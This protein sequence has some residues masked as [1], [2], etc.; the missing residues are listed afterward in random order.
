MTER[1][2]WEGKDWDSSYIE[3]ATLFGVL[4]LSA[5]HIDDCGEESVARHIRDTDEGHRMA[6]H[7]GLVAIALS[8]ADWERLLVE[9]GH[10]LV[11]YIPD[12]P[13]E[14]PPPQMRGG[15]SFAMM[16]EARGGNLSGGFQQALGATG[17]TLGSP[18]AVR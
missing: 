16:Q 1:E 14:E 10:L 3:R 7:G 17:G 13:P 6:G 11:K 4:I 15:T 9:V 12:P 8:P 18:E 2:A 5:P